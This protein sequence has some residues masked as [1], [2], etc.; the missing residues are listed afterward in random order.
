MMKEQNSQYVGTVSAENSSFHIKYQTHHYQYFLT[1]KILT[2]EK[3]YQ[4]VVLSGMENDL[5]KIFCQKFHRIKKSLSVQI[6]ST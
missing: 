6:L 2:L 5:D 1:R 3:Y 4:R